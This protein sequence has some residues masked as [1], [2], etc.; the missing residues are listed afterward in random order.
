MVSDLV[1][2]WCWLGKRRMDDA[3]KLVPDLDVELIFR[4]FE[5]DPTIPVEGVDYKAHMKEKF[6]SD[7]GKDRAYTMRQALIDYGEAEG[8]PYQFDRI[9]RRPNSFNAHR[10]V[11]WAQGQ[12]KGS[13]AK[14]ALFKAYF[15]DG[16]D[17]G[18]TDVLV[19]I[20]REIDLDPAI[21]AELMP[22]D[23]DVE[24]VRNEEALF[25]QMGISGVPTYIANRQVAV[26]GAET[27]E[28]LAKFLRDAAA[29]LPEE[30]P[31]QG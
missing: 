11:R 27:A 20:A 26:Q 10:L 18:E 13:E 17:I 6:G 7:A 23:A 14:E 21:V 29:R 16:R 1:C 31:A 22:T 9:T 24:N 12:Q 25:Q 8:I 28:K 4:P 30:R 5:L 15:Q 2:P 3:I 19:D